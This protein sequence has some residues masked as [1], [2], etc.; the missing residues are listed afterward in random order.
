M[1]H[2]MLVKM[3]CLGLNES[4]SSQV[5]EGA[6]LDLSHHLPFTP[7]PGTPVEVALGSSEPLAVALIKKSKLPLVCLI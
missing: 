3:K 4:S 5:L 2:I 1:T 7:A 6:E